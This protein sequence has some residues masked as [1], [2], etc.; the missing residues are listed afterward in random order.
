MRSWF[1]LDAVGP[2][3]EKLY[4]IY[5]S[6]PVGAF[7]AMRNL[8]QGPKKTSNGELELKTLAMASVRGVVLPDDNQQ[9]KLSVSDQ[10]DD[11]TQF[12]GRDEVNRVEFELLHQ[13][14]RPKQSK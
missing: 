9:L 2:V 4:V 1:T 14:A 8:N 12:I 7:E 3:K 5:S 11:Q 13:G 6:K 10:L